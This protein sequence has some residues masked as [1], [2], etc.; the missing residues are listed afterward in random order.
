[1]IK[2]FKQL[3]GLIKV[4]K[5]KIILNF[6]CF[7]P[8]LLF[9]SLYNPTSTLSVETYKYNMLQWREKIILAEEYLQI[10]DKELKN[11][12]RFNSCKYKVQASRFGSEAYN[13]LLKAKKTGNSLISIDEED[14]LMKN[15][16]KWSSL[17][18]CKRV[19]SLFG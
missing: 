18:S 13:Y 7:V 9:I 14:K 11:G 1:M 19:I 16:E 3:L 17:S 4:L 15:I 6:F 10:S 8:I 2:Y 5:L 12:N